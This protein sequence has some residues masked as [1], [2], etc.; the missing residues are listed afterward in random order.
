MHIVTQ[1]TTQTLCCTFRVASQTFVL[2]T[3]KLPLPHQ[4]SALQH[5]LS[6]LLFPSSSVSW[7]Q[8]HGTIRLCGVDSV[9]S[10]SVLYY[11]PCSTVLHSVTACKRVYTLVPFDLHLQG[12]AVQGFSWNAWPL[13]KGW[14]RSPE[15][16]VTSCQ[17]TPL[18]ITEQRE[19]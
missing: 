9:L 19:R 15:T 13:K 3:V 7:T 5:T 18:S 11:K 2:Y 12:Q 16:S 6:T 8:R 17:P 4:Y 14:I 1:H 10:A